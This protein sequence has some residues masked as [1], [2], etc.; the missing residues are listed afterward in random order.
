M[1]KKIIEKALANM[2]PDR[3]SYFGAIANKLDEDPRIENNA[4]L[5]FSVLKDVMLELPLYLEEKELINQLLEFT[6]KNYASLKA[7]LYDPEFIHHPSSLRAVTGAF[8]H[9]IVKI[10]LKKHDDGEIE[11]AKLSVHTLT[12]PYRDTDVVD[13]EEEPDAW[14][15]AL[16]KNEKWRLE[17]GGVDRRSSGA[18][19]IEDVVNKASKKADPEE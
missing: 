15:E 16:S 3:A 7:A 13:P 19:R 10:S 4:N 11:E 9:Q 1:H 17:N 18:A 8:V 2:D 12:W 6:N 14:A 5:V